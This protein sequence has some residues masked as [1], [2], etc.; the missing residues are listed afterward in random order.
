MLYCCVD[1]YFYSNTQYENSGSA[2]GGHADVGR[3]YKHEGREYMQMQHCS[4]KYGVGGTD[5]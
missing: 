3:E 4:S 5:D 2:T 1:F